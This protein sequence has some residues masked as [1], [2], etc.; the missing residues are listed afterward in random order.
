MSVWYIPPGVP[1][2]SG[3]R[4][5]TRDEG[6]CGNGKTGCG[7]VLAAL[8]MF[9]VAHV[10]TPRCQ[11]HSGSSKG[12]SLWSEHSMLSRLVPREGS[13]CLEC[14][15]L[16]SGRHSGNEENCSRTLEGKPVAWAGQPPFC[17][18]RGL[19]PFLRLSQVP[20]GMSSAKWV[21]EAW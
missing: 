6:H 2:K 7:W 12:H 13:L 19:G 9:K 3:R 5:L 14:M 16:P 8:C 1:E 4:V 20:C 17:T 18:D 21:L 15:A 11:P 10:H